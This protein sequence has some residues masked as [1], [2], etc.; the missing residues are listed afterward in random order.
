MVHIK[1]ILKK[2]NKKNQKKYGAWL[3]LQRW[4][5]CIVC[6]EPNQEAFQKRNE[7]KKFLLMFK[8]HSVHVFDIYLLGGTDSTENR[9]RKKL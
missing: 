3:E 7:I 2:K 1:K 5:R 4:V 8:E 6:G 9:V